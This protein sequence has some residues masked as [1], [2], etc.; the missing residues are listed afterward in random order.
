MY[1]HATEPRRQLRHLYFENIAALLQP[2]AVGSME[3]PIAPPL[4]YLSPSQVSPSDRC[5]DCS[6]ES[7]NTARGF[8]TFIINKRLYGVEYTWLGSWLPTKGRALNFKLKFRLPVDEKLAA[9]IAC[10]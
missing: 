5:D 6:Q 10:L 9:W 2:Y 8:A 4:I 7:V 1:V 3:G